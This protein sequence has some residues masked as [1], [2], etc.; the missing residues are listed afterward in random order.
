M[1]GVVAGGLRAGA[2]PASWGWPGEGV[3]QLLSSTEATNQAVRL[4][5]AHYS[6]Q[7]LHTLSAAPP[8]GRRLRCGDLEFV[9]A[10][11]RTLAELLPGTDDAPRVQYILRLLNQDPAVVGRERF[12]LWVHRESGATAVVPADVKFGVEGQACMARSASGVFEQVVWGAVAAGPVG[13]QQ[14]P[15]RFEQ[16]IIAPLLGVYALPQLDPHLTTGVT[17]PYTGQIQPMSQT[18]PNGLVFQRRAQFMQHMPPAPGLPRVSHAF[19]TLVARNDSFLGVA[20][21]N[22]DRPVLIETCMSTPTTSMC[23]APMAHLKEWLRYL[24]ATQLSTYPSI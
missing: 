12:Q 5:A 1:I 11:T 8:S 14:Q 3:R 22:R 9:D 2:A 21:F 15:I 10:G 20:T 18:R 6:L 19:E 4:T 13:V 7:D 17:N 23:R 16:Q 24:L